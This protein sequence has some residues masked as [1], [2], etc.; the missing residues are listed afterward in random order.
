M[1]SSGLRSTLISA[2]QSL[3]LRAIDRRMDRSASPVDAKGFNE[4]I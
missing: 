1:D 2:T 4:A 3:I